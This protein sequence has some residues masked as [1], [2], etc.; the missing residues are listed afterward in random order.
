VHTSELQDVSQC[1]LPYEITQCYLPADTCEW[2]PLN[3]SQKGWYS[4][5]LPWRDGRLSWPIWLV[6][7][8]DV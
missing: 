3:P 6:T 1:H 8:W 2:A 7:Y 4:I 5:N